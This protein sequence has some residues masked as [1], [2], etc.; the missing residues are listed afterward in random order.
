M[1]QFTISAKPKIT[2][3]APRT[4]SI[5]PDNYPSETNP[6]INLQGKSFLN[7]RAIYLSGSNVSIFPTKT[8]YYNPFSAVKNLSASNLGFRA[9]K[10]ENYYVQGENYIVMEI[11]ESYFDSGYIDVIVENEAGYGLLSRDCRIPFLSTFYGDVDIQSPCISGIKINDFN[12][13][14]ETLI[15]TIDESFILT[16]DNNNLVAIR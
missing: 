2:D 14:K 16:F 12:V 11:P 9:A 5:F 7:I 10:V 6:Y 4:V 13:V 3:A 15:L 1:D 8:T